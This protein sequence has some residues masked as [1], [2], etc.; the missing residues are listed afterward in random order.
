MRNGIA[1][2]AISSLLAYAAC[3]KQET[4]PADEAKPQASAPAAQ[5]KKAAEVKPLEPQQVKKPMVKLSASHILFAYKGAMRAAPTVTRTK[6]E[7][8]ALAKQVCEKIKAGAD[9]AQM[10]KQYSDCPSKERG[11]DLGVFPSNAMAPEFTAGVQALKEGEL[12]PEP[13]ESPFGFHV[14]KRQPVEEIILRQII[15]AYKG[16]PRVPPTVTRTKDEAKK[17]A[18][19]AAVKVRAPGADF[20]ALAQQYSDHPS[21]ARGGLMRPVGRGMLPEAIEKPAFA[22]KENEIAGPIETEMGF[23]IVQRLPSYH[24]RHILV[25]H[26]DSERVPP[27]I[28]RTKEEARARIKEV[29]A[30]VKQPGADFAALAVEYSDCPSKEQ[31]G[32]LGV[33]GPGMMAPPFEKACVDLKPNGISGIVETDFGYHI[34]ERLP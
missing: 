33:F 19:E 3:S 15:V 12:S 20:A 7:A 30:K 29:E 17:L 25:M 11:G 23:M 24:A 2:I 6:E 9:F 26:K 8:Q 21:K 1:M 16:A 14:V 13:V 5:A 18:D 34:I 27:G 4:K 10:A 28:T 22:L 32:D 31:G